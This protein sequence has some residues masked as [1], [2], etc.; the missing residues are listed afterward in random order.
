MVGLFALPQLMRGIIKLPSVKKLDI[1][2]SG[3]GVTLSE[4]RGNF[5]NLVR[6]ALIGTGIGVLPGDGVTAMLIG[7]FEIHG[8]QPGPMLFRNTPEVIQAIYA[9]TCFWREAI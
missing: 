5:V 6:S 8:L 1:E 7:G 2:S 3:I 9:A 4:V